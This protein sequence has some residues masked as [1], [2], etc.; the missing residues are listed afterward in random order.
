MEG[1]FNTL[2]VSYMDLLD[3]IYI[4]YPL[5]NEDLDNLWVLIHKLNF[6]KFADDPAVLEILNEHSICNDISANKRF[7]RDFYKGRSFKC[8]A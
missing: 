3:K 8:S 7:I 1:V 4:G 6:I 2:Y 5:S